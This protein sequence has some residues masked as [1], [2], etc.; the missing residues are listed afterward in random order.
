MM[1]KSL[2]LLFYLK[3][4]KNDQGEQRFVYL[5]IRVNGK[6]NEISTKRKWSTTRW[7]AS[8]NRATG[9]K[10]DAKHLVCF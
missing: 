9:S 1:E 5:R 10:K 3:P 8:T 6:A 2:G 7:N 4:A